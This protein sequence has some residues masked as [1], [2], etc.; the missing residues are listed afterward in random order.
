MNEE[1]LKKLFKYL[2]KFMVFLWKLGLGKTLNFWPKVMGRFLVITHYGRKTGNKYLTPVN[3]S[4]VNG[5][6]YCTS[7]FGVQS[8]WYKN[9]MRNP[10][11]EVWLTEGWWRAQAEDVSDHPDRLDIMREVLIGSGFAAPMFGIQPL[12]MDDVT[13]SEVTKDYRLIRINR[14]AEKTG[15]EGP[16]EYAWFWQLTTVFLF[17]LLIIKKRRK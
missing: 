17:F 14:V 1:L 8:D 10:E 12:R 6:I 9:L 13:L 7:G 4:T 15:N 2:N 5:E 3:Y 16:G 11:I